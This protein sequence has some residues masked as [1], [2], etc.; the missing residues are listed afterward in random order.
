MTNHFSFFKFSIAFSLLVLSTPLFAQE[1]V[2]LPNEPYGSAGDCIGKT[3]VVNCFVSESKTP[4]TTGEKEGIITKENIGFEWLKKQAF[5]WNRPP[6]NFQSIN[7]GMDQ[8]VEVPEIVHGRTVKQI[9]K[10]KIHWTTY[11]LHA[12]GYNNVY[13]FYDSLKSLYQVENVVIM[14]FANKEG[15]SYAQPAYLNAVAFNKEWFV[16]GAVIYKNY[17]DTDHV[18]Y[19]GTIM[20]EML[21]L[22]GSWDMYIDDNRSSDVDDIV[23]GLFRHSIMLN[24]HT[25]LNTL[26]IDQ[27]TA[28]RI[29]WIKS[30]LPCYEVFRNTNDPKVYWEKM[31]GLLPVK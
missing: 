23:N 18:L 2:N 9:S 15:R 5:K 6:I 24:D 29:G 30:Y 13:K 14:V 21:H 12:A 28:W 25:D 8:D 16:E 31:P 4:W 17:F 3:L 26:S 22:F 11:A 27:M 19:T 20:H 10:L 7:I 1:R